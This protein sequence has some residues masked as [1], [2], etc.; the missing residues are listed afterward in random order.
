MI[1][2]AAEATSL[3]APLLHYVAKTE[4]ADETVAKR[5]TELVALDAGFRAASARIPRDFDAGRAAIAKAFPDFD[6]DI[7]VRF[8]HSLGNFDGGTR[9]FRGRLYLLFGADMIAQYHAW[10]DDRAFFTHELFHAYQAQLRGQ[11]N[12]NAHLTDTIVE[13]KVAR[14]D[15]LYVALWEEG[16]A[17]Y[18]S[19]WLNPGIPHASLG[20]DIPEGMEA[21]CLASLPFLVED[22]GAKL[23]STEPSDYF[24]YMGFRSKD[25]R[26]PK[27]AGYCVGHLVARKLHRRIAMP[28]SSGSK[29]P[30]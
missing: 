18:V 24:D 11:D 3:P 14:Q 5:M 12:R 28:S 29:A 6:P 7:R 16:L 1:H 8:V 25:P 27:R 26:R 22:L 2:V 13:D 23:E 30:R 19:G 9:V 15:P 21:T 10:T 4:A 17:T 20:L